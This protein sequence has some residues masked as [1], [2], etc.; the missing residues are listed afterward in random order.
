MCSRFL[1][2]N[3]IRRIGRGGAAVRSGSGDAE[4]G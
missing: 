4:E 1:L 3:S 2:R